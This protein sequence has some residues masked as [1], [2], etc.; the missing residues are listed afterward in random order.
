MRIPSPLRRE[1]EA[2]GKDLGEVLAT[3]YGMIVVFAI[4]FVLIFVPAFLHYHHG[5]SDA[6]VNAPLL[7]PQ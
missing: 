5:W 2:L 7:G 1:T 6:G 4:L 3:L